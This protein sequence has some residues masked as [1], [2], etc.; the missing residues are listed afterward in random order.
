MSRQACRSGEMKL[1]GAGF[2]HQAGSA[3]L[4][5]CLEEQWVI[6]TTL[7]HYGTILIFKGLELRNK[8]SNWCH[9]NG[10]VWTLFYNWNIFS[11]LPHYQL[12]MRL[13]LFFHVCMWP[14]SPRMKLNFWT[15]LWMLQWT[16]QKKKRHKWLMNSWKQRELS[17]STSRGIC[18][19][20]C[21]YKA[22][23]SS[24][25]KKG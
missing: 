12:K 4:S 18:L 14:E 1:N 24:F 25:S 19:P 20:W 16:K 7:S 15:E 9:Q 8:E 10:S 3:H 23:S 13:L 17:H 22:K 6:P 21:S 11:V 2:I 5:T